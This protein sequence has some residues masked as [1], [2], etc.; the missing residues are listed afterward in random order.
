MR[1][2]IRTA[3]PL[4]T[5]SEPGRPRHTGQTLLFG[6]APNDVEQPQKILVSGE[7]LR[8]HLEADDRLELGRHR[9]SPRASVRVLAIDAGVRGIARLVA[10]V[11][12]LAR[13]VAAGEPPSSRSFSKMNWSRES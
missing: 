10:R 3:S 2:A 12:G 5:G 6:R 4:S 8:V 7:E 11:L 9:P 1:T 13:P